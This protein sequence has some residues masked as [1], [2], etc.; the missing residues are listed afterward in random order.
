MECLEDILLEKG[1]S[2]ESLGPCFLLAGTYVA[3]P[4]EKVSDVCLF[5]DDVL[6]LSLFYWN[7]DFEPFVL[8]VVNQTF[9]ERSL[10]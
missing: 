9:D 7:N 4:G 8:P 5:G 10:V 2:L 1:S 6:M 3:N